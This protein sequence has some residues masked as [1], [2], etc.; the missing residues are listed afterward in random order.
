[1]HT[2]STFSALRHQCGHFSIP[3][4][5]LQPGF[6][7]PQSLS[8]L[9]SLD[10]VLFFILHSFNTFC[11]LHFSLQHFPSGPPSLLV[12]DRLFH[13][14]NGC[15]SNAYSDSQLANISLHLCSI[16]QIQ[17]NN[18][19]IQF[20]PLA[21]YELSGDRRST[22]SAKNIS[23]QAEWLRQSGCAPSEPSE[24]PRWRITP[25]PASIPPVALHIALRLLFHRFFLLCR[26]PISNEHSGVVVNCDHTSEWVHWVRACIGITM[27]WVTLQ[28][29]LL[30]FLLPARKMQFSLY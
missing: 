5:S 27:R 14:N 15:L 20:H 10:L 3:I 13:P 18:I 2:P 4:S 24:T 6:S 1:M 23:V 17:S 16:L 26:S 29:S 21:M 8:A 25:R 19:G 11:V 9:L 7:A 12:V 22:S 28:K 30:A